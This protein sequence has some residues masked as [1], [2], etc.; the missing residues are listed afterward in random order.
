VAQPVAHGGHPCDVL[1][2]CRAAHFHLDRPVAAL[3][4]LGRLVEQLGQGK[5]E[6][7]AA[8]IGADARVVA[9][10]EAPERQ[11]GAA[12]LEIPQGRVEGGH[13]EARDAAAAHPM[14]APPH[15]L[16]QALDA[17]RFLAEAEGDE[18]VLEDRPDRLAP[19]A[20]RI[21]VADP[22]GPVGV[23]HARGYELEGG[24]LAVRG[25]GEHDGQGNAIVVDGDA[26]DLH[27]P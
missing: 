7:D 4:V 23:R 18:V 17:V 11:V 14:H 27:G 1:A 25:I 3:E 2:E 16:P 12:C 21:G 24:D 9:S 10:E 20:H 6:V 13:A 15:P 22:L 5:V 19:M 8:G 26:L